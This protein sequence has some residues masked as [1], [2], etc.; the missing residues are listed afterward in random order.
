MSH[1]AVRD[2]GSRDNNFN[3]L[4]LIAASAVLVSHAYPLSLGVGTPEPLSASL[5]VSLGALAVISFFIISGYF[6]SQSFDNSSSLL[7]FT[8]ARI[9]RIYPALI[10]VL[11][12]TT[13]VIGPLFTR[14]SPWQFFFNTETLSYVPRNLSLKWLQYGLPGVFDHNPYPDAI[15][16]SLW[17][18]VYEVTCYALVASLGV[19]GTANRNWIFGIFFLLYVLAYFAVS[20]SAS[21]RALVTD[22]P[23]FETLRELSFPFVFGM[24]IYRGRKALLPRLSLLVCVAAAAATIVASQTFLFR[25]VLILFWGLLLFYVGYLPVK[26]L[27]RYNGLG[28]YSY[29]MYIYAFPCEQVIVYLWNGVSAIALTAVSFPITLALAVLSW[30]FVEQPALTR[31]KNATAWFQRSCSAFRS[32]RTTENEKHIEM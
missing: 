22:H 24:L 27:R 12:L 4:R 13:F 19:F 26:H 16:G 3:L 25:E 15:N 29:G 10:A 5:S 2:F 18:L 31:K 7:G 9:L 20:M 21:L 6:I 17:T 32:E 14:L 11:L 28:D 23:F 1:P 30:H 8:V